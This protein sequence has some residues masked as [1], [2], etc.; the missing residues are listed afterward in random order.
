M[1]PKKSPNKKDK[2]KPSSAAGDEF[3]PEWVTALLEAQRHHA[4]RQEQRYEEQ[5]E[6][7]ERRHQEQIQHLSQFISRSTATSAATADG[8]AAGD[9]AAEQAAATGPDGP[10]VRAAHPP[11]KLGRDVSLR[12][13]KSWRLAWKDYATLARL[14]KLST[15]EQI[16]CLRTCLTEEMRA[17]LEHVIGEESSNPEDVLDKI[18]E[19]L[20]SQRNVALDRVLFEERRQEEGESFDNFFVSLKE[21]AGE[22]ELCDQCV[23]DRLTT[24][25]ISGIRDAE[26]RR[27]LLAIRPFPTLQEA[28]DRCRSAE[29]SRCNEAD[30]AGR[31]DQ[32]VARLSQQRGYARKPSQAPPR[33]SEKCGFC[34]ED[35]HESQE[36]VPPGASSV[37][38]AA[39]RITWGWPADRRGLIR[40]HDRPAHRE[41]GNVWRSLRYDR[42][43][44]QM[45]S[46][47][48]ARGRHRLYLSRYWSRSSGLSVA[49]SKLCL[50]LVPKRPSS[51][52]P[53]WPVWVYSGRI[54]RRATK[55]Q[56][57]PQTDRRWHVLERSQQRSRSAIEKLKTMC[58]SLTTYSLRW[59]RGMCRWIWEFFP[60]TIPRPN[61]LTWGSM[62]RL[63]RSTTNT[64]LGCLPHQMSTRRD[65]TKW[66]PVSWRQLVCITRRMKNTSW[67]ALP[68][69]GNN[70]SMSFPMYSPPMTNWSLWMAFRC[71]FIF[72]RTPNRTPWMQ[73][74]TYPWHGETLWRRKSTA[75]S[76]EAL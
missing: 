66:R 29:I 69:S 55:R 45:S 75:C 34:G 64:H 63:I 21:L 27:H 22:A 73:Q 58:T 32:M 56:S 26:A 60:K 59:C 57:V 10:A 38:S 17:T 51:G 18:E 9:N 28:V 7:L 1:P 46:E 43:S 37:S 36:N 19:Y 31:T 65:T 24:R 44:S 42:S 68:A 67:T 53:S 23:E 8:A 47:R 30:L 33:R 76:G 2:D 11:E 40:A 25:I 16:A 13:F 12:T 74:E 62:R 54:C 20:R 3:F 14:N 72:R 41:T 5:V 61:R 52:H 15:Q 6:R 50:I 39:R 71:T 4:E 49:L 70:F 48:G 35:A